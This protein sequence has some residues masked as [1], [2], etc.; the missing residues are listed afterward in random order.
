MPIEVL[1]G[2]GTLILLAGLAWA[3]I[4]YRRSWAAREQDEYERRSG[5]S[6]NER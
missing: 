2:L 5:Q 6:A 3:V 1:W 4:R